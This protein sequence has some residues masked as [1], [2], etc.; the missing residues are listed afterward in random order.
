MNGHVAKPIDPDELFA[1]LLKWIPSRTGDVAGQPTTAARSSAQASASGDAIG[2]IPG[3]DIKAGLRRVLNKRASYENLLR[4]FIAGQADAVAVIRSQLA[5]SEREAAQR[6]AHTLKGVA[7]TIGAA[8]LQERAGAV[9]HAVKA[10]QAATEIEVQLVAVQEELARLVHALKS[11]LPPEPAASA[12]AEVDWA[13]AREIVARIEALL[14]NDDSEAV[15]LF[16]EH[17]ALLRAA[18]GNAAATIEK[19]LAR[20]M[21]LDAL[22]ALRQVKSSIPQLH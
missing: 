10:G 2:A 6:A 12:A 19:D 3:L 21:F 17:A 13:R 7:G 22:A 4:K 1:A 9:E 8:L 16:N 11:A 14:A 20:F 5:A 15:E 18:C